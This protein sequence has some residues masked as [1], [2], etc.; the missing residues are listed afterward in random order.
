MQAK[1]PFSI[2]SNSRFS[3]AGRKTIQAGLHRCSVE[4]NWT[5][6]LMRLTISSL[7]RN[8]AASILSLR[9]ASK[10]ETSPPIYM[11]RTLSIYRDAFRNCK[12]ALFHSG[13]I[14]YWPAS[15]LVFWNSLAFSDR[16]FYVEHYD[17]W[18]T[19][20]PNRDGA[21]TSIPANLA[22][23]R[24]SALAWKMPFHF[25]FNGFK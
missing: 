20:F 2:L 10:T 18:K 7:S 9:L 8:R 3:A 1:L 15:V 17:W 24:I 22:M 4:Q 11:W 25:S 6:V 19:P 23:F 13:N 5:K 16:F 14:V 21:V 12:I